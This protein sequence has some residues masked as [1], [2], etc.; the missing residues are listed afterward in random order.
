MI[1]AA[2][3]YVRTVVWP[4]RFDGTIAVAA[5]NVR[6]QPWKHSSR[7]S[8]VDISAPGESVWRASLN[9]DGDYINYMGK[10]TTFA[11]GN[12]AAAAALWLSWHRDNPI[13][14]E[15][16]AQGLITSAFRE[17]LV[18][19][20]WMPSTVESRPTET[21]C[22]DD[23]WNTR[24]FGPGIINIDNLLAVPLEVPGTRSI[25]PV[26]LSLIPLFASLYP[27]DAMPEKI[28]QDYRGL[29]GADDS[30]PINT[31]DDLETELLYHY[32]MDDDV[33]RTIDGIVLGQRSAEP[34][35]RARSA[36]RDVDVSRR[37]YERLQE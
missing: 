28:L 12:T 22:T 8:R 37:L 23:L 33:Q 14:A 2:G 32:T 7:G 26:D 10:G 3:N 31:L 24:Q 34:L 1:A 19:S 25:A 30:E 29:L 36:L 11:T 18:R 5:V 20:A 27:A 21:Q 9:K 13:L 16:R 35:Q 15:L 4:A 6:C 17:A